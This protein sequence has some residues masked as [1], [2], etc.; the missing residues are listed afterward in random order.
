MKMGNAMMLDRGRSREGGAENNRSE[1]RS[2]CLAEH[3]RISWLS[4]A[5]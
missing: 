3:F 4:F 1:K 5:T 2:F